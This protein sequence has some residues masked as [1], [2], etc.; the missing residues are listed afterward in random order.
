M[1]SRQR[2]HV[3]VAQDE[4][5]INAFFEKFGNADFD[6]PE[7]RDTG[8]SYFIDKIYLYD[9]GHF[10]VTGWYWDFEHEIKSDLLEDLPERASGFEYSLDLDPRGVRLLR[11]RGHHRKRASLYRRLCQTLDQNGRKVL[12]RRAGVRPLRQRRAF[13]CAMGALAARGGGMARVTRWCRGYRP[14]SQQ[15]SGSSLPRCCRS[16]WSS[17]KARRWLRRRWRA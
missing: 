8:L 12:S 16:S 11:G 17:R 7:T 4:S 13:G 15:S 5:S 3:R 2:R 1:P 6:D 9:D 10:E 14:R